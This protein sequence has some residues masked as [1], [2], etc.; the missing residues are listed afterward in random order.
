MKIEETED[1]RELDAFDARAAFLGIAGAARH[2]R[3]LL[4]LI[5]L[6]TLA[7]TTVYVL[8]WPPVYEA[9]ATIMV[10][11]DTDPV[12]DSFYIGWNVFRKD[13]A[14]TEIELMQSGPL[15]REVV[16]KEK[17]TYDDVYHPMGSYLS[18]LWGRSWVGQRYREAKRFVLGAEDAGGMSPQE[19]ELARTIVDLRSGVSIA[20]IAE[21]NVGRLTVIGPSRRVAA[22]ANSISEIYLRQRADRYH[23]EARKAY[24]VLSE[25]VALAAGELA[26]IEARRLQVVK[27]STL[28]FDFQ[29]EALEVQKLTDLE[30]KVANTRTQIAAIDATLGEIGRQL[31]SDP[32]TRVPA[33]VREAIKMKRMEV[34]TSLIEARLRYREDSPEVAGYHKALKDIDA[35][36]DEAQTPR[37]QITSEGLSGIQQDLLTRRNAL[38]AERLGSQAGLMVMELT[39]STLRSRLAAVPAKQSAIRA[40]D[41]DY[42]LSQ[43]KYQELLSKQAQAAVSVA[44]A[45]TTMASMRVVEA[46]VPPQK[47]SWPRLWILYPVALI[48]SLLAGLCIAVLRSHVDG[49]I[50]RGVLEHGRVAMPVYGTLVVP[51]GR[52]PL[53]SVM[54]SGAGRSTTAGSEA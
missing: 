20:P 12:R 15:L 30:E 32:P 47:P 33:S 42:A 7:L 46:A 24:D 29:K 10:E 2:H 18:H 44:T 34:E 5:A 11:R 41:R 21:S 43:Q 4:I 49:R 37:E 22:M 23:Q 1:R 9:T 51:S 6:F 45:R 17:L 26:V 13:D 39:A 3:R 28:A 31:Q 19:L 25:E 52:R 36:I 35:L 53:V 14:R 50:R 54:H 27:G 48:V 38:S 40:L 8:V 16:E